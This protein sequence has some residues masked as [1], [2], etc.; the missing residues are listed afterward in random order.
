MDLVSCLNELD[1]CYARGALQEADAFLARSIAEAEA[2]S[3][4]A[5]VLSLLN[6]QMGLYRVTG[7]QEQAV[8]LSERA[9]ALVEKLGLTDSGFHATVLLNRATALGV[10]GRLEEALETYRRAETIYDAAGAASFAYASLLNNMSN[11]Q[12]ALGQLDEAEAC[13]RKSRRLLS[14][15]ADTAAELA[16]NAVNLAVLCIR[17]GAL[18]EAES[19]IETAMAYYDKDGRMDTHR[20]SSIAARGMLALAQGRLEDALADDRAALELTLSVFGECRDAEVL[21]QNIT[22]LEKELEKRHEG[23]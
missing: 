8:A 9:L 11:I 18:G 22:Q 23:A 4:S 14:E 13:L 1:S 6:E 17:R 2:E 3:D 16:T 20:A 7:R 19:W 12:S 5:A 10:A 21:R 15:D